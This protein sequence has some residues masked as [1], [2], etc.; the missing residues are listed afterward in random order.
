MHPKVIT[1]G[2]HSLILRTTEQWD[3]TTNSGLSPILDIEWYT[4]ENGG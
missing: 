1:V 3:K 4:W 2:Y